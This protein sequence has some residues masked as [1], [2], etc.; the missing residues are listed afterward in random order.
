TRNNLVSMSITHGGTS[1]GA[2]SKH[3]ERA[4]MVYE[5]IRQDPEVYHLMNY[6]LEGVQYVIKDGKRFRPDGYDVQ[7][8]EFYSNFWGGRIDKNEIPDGNDWSGK[9]ALY[10]SYDKIKKPFP[11]GRFV[12][13]KAPVTNELTAVT[14]VVGQMG[15]AILYGKAGDP[16]KAVDDFRAKLKTAGFDKLMAEVQKQLDA[17]KTTVESSK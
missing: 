3:P 4:L 6:G 9:G 8:D 5:L 14:Q 17:F 1:I 11:Y 10:A 13:D 16:V 2:K 12:F 15:P 7:R